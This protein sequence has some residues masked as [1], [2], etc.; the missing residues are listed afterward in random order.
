MK[1]MKCSQPA[2]GQGIACDRDA[3]V[4]LFTTPIDAF[5]SGR[6]VRQGIDA[7]NDGYALRE[8]DDYVVLCLEHVANA[9]GNAMGGC[10]IVIID[11]NDMY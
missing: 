7:N 3:H 10:G 4:A 11:L 1:N 2:L 5:A 9:I 6:F 8:D